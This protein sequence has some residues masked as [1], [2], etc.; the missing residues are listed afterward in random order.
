M[1]RGARRAG[2]RAG[3]R[4]TRRRTSRR[5]RRRRRI[6][7]GGFVLLAAGGAAY[8]AYKLSKNDA[9]RIEEKT[10]QSVEEMSE[11]DLAA[12][13]KELGIQSIELTD[14]DK[15]IISKEEKQ[16]APDAEGAAGGDYL[17]ELEKLADLRD[18]GVITEEEFEAKKKEILEI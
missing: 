14:D 7:V 8:G 16:G 13:M 10:G 4:T 12:A 1:P 9:D 17:A 18:R 5:R 2:R 3:R 6:M 15:A 11:E